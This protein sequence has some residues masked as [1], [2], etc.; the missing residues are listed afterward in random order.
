MKILVKYCGG[1]NPRFDRVA[2]VR[3]VAEDFPAVEIVYGAD[4]EGSD[5]VL[6]VCGC[7]VCCALHEE[8]RGKFGKRVISSIEEYPLLFE[9]LSKLEN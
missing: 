9:E 4:L 2:L 1:C 8:L 5:F 3:K 6:V 7:P